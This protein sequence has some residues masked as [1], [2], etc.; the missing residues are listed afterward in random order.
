MT[1]GAPAA[2]FHQAV[3][4]ALRDQRKTKLWL[5]QETGIARNTINAWETQP[6]PPQARTVMAVADALGMDRIEA[7]QLAGIVPGVT[8]EVEEDAVPLAAVDTDVLLAEIRRR[9]PD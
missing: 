2:P 5:H 7:L 4:R 8:V 9:I 3:V 6:R 1:E